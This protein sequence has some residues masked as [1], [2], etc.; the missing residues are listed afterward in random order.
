M[1]NP[2]TGLTQIDSEDITDGSIT[3]AKLDPSVNFPSSLFSGVDPT[4]SQKNTFNVGV[5]GFKM[6]VN[7]G[8]TIFNL[9]DG[10]VDEFNSES[11]VDTSENA[12]ALYNSTSDFYSNQQVNNVE[13]LL[14]TSTAHLADP[15]Q[16]PIITYAAQ[17]IGATEAQ[18]VADTTAPGSF[19]ASTNYYKATQL[20][21]FATNLACCN[22]FV[23]CN[24]NWWRWWFISRWS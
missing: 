24:I 14:T 8:L 18:A 4:L 15:S 16:A 19:T 9:I 5:I 20:T 2:L 21:S 17:G 12:N 23:Y 13:L 22:N 10:V 1:P 6:A 11:G 7:E 3:S